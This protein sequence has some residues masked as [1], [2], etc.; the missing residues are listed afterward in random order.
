MSVGAE[1]KDMPVEMRVLAN[2]IYE[3][4]KGVRPLVL[5]T[6]NRRYADYALSKLRRSGISYI[7]QPAG[8]DTIN[9]FFGSSEC[10]ETI[11]IIASKPLNRLSPE[12]DFMLGALLGYDIRRQCERFCQ[13]KCKDCERAASTVIKQ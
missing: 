9:L 7:L 1:T 12:E 6:F 3:Y 2:H 10:L 8:Q 11:R 13:R 5:Y 4:N